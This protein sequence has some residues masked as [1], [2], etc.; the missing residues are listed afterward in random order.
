MINILELPKH[1]AIKLWNGLFQQDTYNR[2]Q[3]NLFE[4]WAE[5]FLSS[6][7]DLC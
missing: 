1:R 6:V 7:Y 3:H 5:Y 2:Q 4:L